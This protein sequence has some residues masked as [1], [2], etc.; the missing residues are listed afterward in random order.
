MTDI[1]NNQIHHLIARYGRV[2]TSLQED[3]KTIE[4]QLMSMDEFADKKFGVGNYTIV[5]EYLDDGW[6]GDNIKRPQLDQLRM[7]AAKKIWDTVLIYDPDRLARRGEWQVIIAEELE[8]Q[9][10][11]VLFVTVPKAKSDYDIISNKMRGVFAEYERMKIAERFRLGKLRKVQGGN[12]LTTEAPYGY[13]YIRNNKETKKHGYYVINEDEAKN[14]RMIFNWVGENGL[15]I[16]QVV[17]KLQELD[18]KPKKSKRGVWSTS[19]LSTMLKHKGYIGKTH[20]GA[21]YAVVPDHPRKMDKYRQVKKSSR[22]TKPEADWIA[23]NIPIPRI[24]EDELFF[25]VRTQLETNFALCQRNTKNEYL[26]GGKIFCACGKRRCGEGPQHGKHLYYRCSDRVYSFPLPPSCKEKGINAR[27]ADKLVWQE[28]TKLMS[29]PD[30]LQEQLDQWVQERKGKSPSFGADAEIIKKDIT[31]LE[32]QVKRYNTIF[33]EGLLS[34]TKLKESTEPTI[35]RIEKLREQIR[36]VEQ[37]EKLID[38]AALPAEEEIKLLSEEASQVFK[39]P[40]LNFEGKQT[41]IRNAVDKIIGTQKQLQVS[42]KISLTFLNYVKHQTD[43]RHSR[44][45]KCW[46]KHTF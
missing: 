11:N 12:V 8:E 24:I 20:W 18:I 1:I 17:R 43:Y 30:L 13:R 45:A 33:A 40:D 15:T 14:V 38:V 29:S 31:K 22:R 4:N 7:D 41:I 44:P 32:A 46:Q 3:Q 5:K 16:R 6:S 42:G 9:G 19:T 23:P 37:E 26:V 35:K 21:S 28:M 39:D 27:I 2:S 34:M 10:A 36:K 25:K